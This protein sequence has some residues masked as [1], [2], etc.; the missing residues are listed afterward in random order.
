MTKQIEKLREVR[1]T[2]GV[3]Y[4]RCYHKANPHGAIVVVPHGDYEFEPV[5]I[6]KF[7]GWRK[8]GF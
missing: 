7:E 4:G 2:F 5:Y 3:W 1:A 6:L 8:R